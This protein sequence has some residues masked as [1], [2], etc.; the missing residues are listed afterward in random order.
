VR[1]VLVLPSS[2]GTTAELWDSNVPLWAD[3]FRPLPYDQRGRSSVAEL[4]EDL[5]ALMDEHGLE[6]ASICGLS[7]GGA[8]AMW[9]AANAPER[10]DRLVLAC[11]SA[12]F[13]EPGPWLER[14][15]IVREHGLEPI[16]DGIVGRW[17]TPAAPSE[18]VARFRQMLVETPRESYATCCEALA[19]WDFRNHLAEITAPTLVIAAAEDPA[20]PPE[21][22]ELLAH[23]IPN[24][25][26][27]A[28]P[29]AAHL[30]NVE[31]PETFS[32]FVAEHLAPVKEVA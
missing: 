12:R 13:G 32:S 27:T 16:A 21:H 9:V 17:F 2:L 30:A 1:P 24:A 7:L 8:T 28:L 11:T 31:Q 23:G 4:G 6:R 25:T 3:S 29:D 26:L 20:T 5:I 10:V 18:L 15:A 19:R 14:A 22:A